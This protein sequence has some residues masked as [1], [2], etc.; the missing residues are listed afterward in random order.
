LGAGL[1]KLRG[2]SCWTDLSC[3]LY[4]YE[5]QPNP[6]PLSWLLHH[7]PTWFQ[8]LGVLVNHAVEVVAPFGLFGPR[9]LRHIAGAATVAF[10]VMLILS[11]NLAFLNWLTIVIAIACFDDSLL[12]RSLPKRWAERLVDA[13]PVPPSRSRRWVQASL[14]AIVA[15]LSINPIANLLSSHQRMNAGFDPFD[16]VTSYGA[17]GSISRERHEVILEGARASGGTE[18][19]PDQLEWRE[20]EFPCKPGDPLRAPCIVTPYHYRL[21][22]QMWF[23]SL[24]RADREPWIANLAYKLLV[25]DQRV[26]GLLRQNPFP[27]AP[28]EYVRA[29]LYRYRFTDFGERG[30]WKR[31]RVGPYL[32]VLSK[33]DPGLLRFLRRVGWLEP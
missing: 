32:P 5:T 22:W 25:G 12:A 28:P 14:C 1:I 31:E 20:Y 21:D 15:V 27:G 3:L 23:A 30:W 16:L 11:G 8:E 6:H 19:N 9:R 29:T 24:S 33:N 10:Q 17:F 18:L 4:H 13:D 2:D 26:L 7:A